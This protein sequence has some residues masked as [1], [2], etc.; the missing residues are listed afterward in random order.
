MCIIGL[1]AQMSIFFSIWLF[2]N[3]D[4]SLP[5]AGE[6]FIDQ[7]PA[8]YAFANTTEKFTEDDILEMAGIK[9]RSEQS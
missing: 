6:V 4:E 7:K 8:C 3:L 1:K 2:D 9:I 5:F